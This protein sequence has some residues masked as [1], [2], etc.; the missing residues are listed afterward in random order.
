MMNPDINKK[1]K[2]SKPK[3]ALR[4]KNSVMS[5]TT[6][7]KN[8]ATECVCILD[9]SGSMHPLT[10]DTI[11]GYNRMLAEQKQIPGDARLTLVL[12]DDKV[13]TIYESKPLSEVPNLDESIYRATGTTALYDAIGSTIENL[14][15]RIESLTAKPKVII[16]IFTD[17]EENAS[18]VYRKAQIKELIE[19]R[20]R[21]GWE[22]VFIGAGIDAMTAGTSI[23]VSSNQ[24]HSVSSDAKGMSHT[25]NMVSRSYIGTRQQ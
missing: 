3:R 16:T 14:D 22:V 15:R 24:I 2:V 7:E 13:K 17:G 21:A 10:Q 5:V 6:E 12:F 25:F 4:P 8:I 1:T 20:Q 11:G 9:K 23:G 18:L 19:V